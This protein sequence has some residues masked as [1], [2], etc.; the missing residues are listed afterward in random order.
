MSEPQAPALRWFCTGQEIY[1]AMLEA[2]RSARASIRLE[3]Y[4]YTD[5]RLGRDFLL[6][7]LEATQ[8]GVRVRVL[9]DAFGSWLLRDDFF[10]PLQAAGAEVDFFNPLRLWRFGVRDHRKL[11]VCDDAVLFIGGFNIADEFDGDGVTRGWCDLG[12]R[13]EGPALAVAMARS[14]DELFKLA[15]FHRKPLVRLRA[16]KRKRK[17]EPRPTEELLLSHPGRGASPFQFAL[18]HD[19]ASARDIRFISAYFLPTRRIRRYL[20]RAARN[21]CRVQL[22]LA[23]RSDVLISQLAARSLYHRLLKAGVEIYEYQPQIL[24]AKLIIADGITYAGSSN[25]DIRS[26]NLNYELMLRF[27]DKSIAA[28]AQEIFER[29]LKHSRRIEPGTWSKAQTWWQRWQYRWAHFLVARIDPFIA[30]RQFR[31]VKK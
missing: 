21:G 12:A 30:L 2:I 15:A 16:F 23:G 28:G 19:L 17:S 24:H 13:V 5:G 6:A 27:E 22:I 1:P 11:L 31:A 18:H 14:F 10:L 20:Q 3:T 26:L 4:I 29:T 9:V 8:R 7:L 25:L